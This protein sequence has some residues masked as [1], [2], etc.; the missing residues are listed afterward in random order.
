MLS[1]DWQTED[2]AIRL[3]KGDMREVLKSFDAETFTACVTDPPYELG[4]M[5]KKWDK[6]G[7]VNNP[8][9]WSEVMRVLKPGAHLLAF[10]GTRTVHRMT[11]AI[12]DAGFECRDLMLWV[13]GSGFPKSLDI[14]KQLD[15]MAGAEREKKRYDASQVGNFKGRQD[16]R[17]WI[18]NAKAAGYHEVDGDIPVTAAAAAWQ[19]YGTA[20]KP[21]CE[22]IV[23]ARKPISESTIAG[24]C[25]KHG[26]GALNIDEC[27]VQAGEALVRPS[28]QR[29]DNEVYGKGL[30]AG[31]QVE[32]KGRWPANLIHDGSE[33]VL[34][35]FPQTGPSNA[36]PPTGR[37]DR[38]VPGFV[39]RR[40]DTDERGISDNGGSAARFFYCAKASKSDRGEGNTHATVKPLELM[41]YLV[42]LVKMPGEN[43]IL[44][45]FA[46]S[47]TTLLAC[48][49]QFIPCVGIDLELDHLEIMERRA[50]N[51]VDKTPLLNK[52][53]SLP[54]QKE[55]L[56]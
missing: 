9:T 34:A 41:E 11:C 54:T 36:R 28:V 4:F 3:H 15:K 49:N 10:G 40:Q 53:D 1:P 33:E 31:T 8:E 14:S 42:K 35:G 20:L 38:G 51:E 18:E 39:M 16:S 22:I 46:G 12:E 43:K 2:G 52:V 55:F 30:G 24:N 21:A 25:L 6:T 50:K 44:E 27:R 56:T 45:P 19:G 26:C 23:I 29:S 32:P 13:Y 5:G 17:P 48:Y 47:G 7:V 37:D